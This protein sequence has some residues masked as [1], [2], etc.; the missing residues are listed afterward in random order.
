MLWFF[1]NH[2]PTTL[3]DYPLATFLAD[4]YFFTTSDNSFSRFDN[5]FG[6][7]VR[8]IHRVALISLRVPLRWIIGVSRHGGLYA[9]V[10]P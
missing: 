6:Y 5:L 2:A 7:F 10:S 8:F 4:D 9:P 3:N 1:I